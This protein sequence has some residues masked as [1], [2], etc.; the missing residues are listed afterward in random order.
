MKFRART[1]LALA[2]PLMF[3]A[4][5]TI[6]PPQP[7]SLDLPKTPADL[8]A[9]R[10]GDRVVLTWTIPTTT[11]DRQIIRTLGP[12]E[13]CRASTPAMQ[14]CGTPVGKVAAGPSSAKP[15][16]KQ[17]ATG[18]YTDVLSPEFQSDDPAAYAT[19]AVEVLNPE[20]RGAGLS[21]RIKV[22]LIR[23]A[24]P[25]N[26]FQ[27]RVSSQG[28]ALNWTG[29][30]RSAPPQI[31]CVYR[32]YR[33]GQD[34]Q[35]SSIGE[36]PA[37]RGPSYTFTDSQIEWEKT[38]EYRVETVT[39]IASPN[40]PEVQVE[41][42][43]TQIA[44]VFAHD[45]FPP[46]VPAGL[47]AVFS[48]PGQQRFIDLVWAPVSDADLGGYSVYRRTEKTAPTKINLGSVK[49]PAYRDTAVDSGMR[50]FYA[51]ASVDLR[52]NESARSEETSEAV[53]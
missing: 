22:P 9:T 53:P 35:E 18:S 29:E 37:D 30:S 11:T 48:G 49:M 38:Y 1:L 31:H 41:G 3:A 34:Q 13:I 8:K 36:V 10:K 16:S 21:N 40:K 44:K 46:A 4:C 33:R 14:E 52:G 50:Y 7:P 17:R 12:T 6:G 5:A 45:I 32:V 26:D 42:D 20:G 28:I 15:S 47:Q 25:P 51:V 24:P 23:T 19:Y 27:A 43:D 39:G 2:A